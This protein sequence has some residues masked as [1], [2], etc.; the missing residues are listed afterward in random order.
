MALDILATRQRVCERKGDRLNPA[1]VNRILCGR[2]VPDQSDPHSRC[3]DDRRVALNSVAVQKLSAASL[4][5]GGRDGRGHL[6]RRGQKRRILRKDV[7]GGTFV[8]RLGRTSDVPAQPRRIGAQ[9]WAVVRPL[10]RRNP[11]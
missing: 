11:T 4:L 7:A 3:V 9:D 10:A 8:K 2:V 6:S 5:P 1:L